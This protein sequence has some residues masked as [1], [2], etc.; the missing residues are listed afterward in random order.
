MAVTQE[1]LV[2]L[3]AVGQRV[4]QRDMDDSAKSVE[5]VGKASESTAKAT[6]KSFAKWV[7]ASGAVAAGSKVLK[8]SIGNAVDLG[9]QINK[10]A[11][12]F[13]GPGAKAVVDWSKSTATAIGV[14]RQQALEA[15]GTFGNMLVPMGFARTQAAGMS[16]KLVTLAGDMASFNNANPEDTLEALRSGLAGETEPLRKYGVFLNDAR[17]KAEAMGLGLVHASRDQQKIKAS[18]LA[19]ELAQRKYNAA[20]NK[21]GAHSQQAKQA[22]L[23]NE[24]AQVAL[25]KATKGSIPQLT[26]AQKAQATYSLILKDTKDAQ[27]DFG[28]TSDSLANKQRILKAQYAN[29]T[30]TLGQQLVPVLQLLAN[31]LDVVAAA[32][33]VLTTAWVA[34]RV[35]ALYAAASQTALNASIFLIPTAIIAVVAALVIAYKKVGWFHDA[36]NATF[37]WIKS[38]WP[39]LAAILAGPFG[40]AA[41][42][43]IRNFDKIKNA[44][45]ATVSWIAKRFRDLVDFFKRLPGGVLGKVGGL[46]GKIT[47]FQHGGVSRGGTALVGEAGPE[48]VTLPGGTRVT[49]LP[50]LGGAGLGGPMVANLYLDR[51]LVA[52]AVAQ[53]DA[54]VRARR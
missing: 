12:V 50:A 41:L 35:A 19:A 10:T 1:V 31:N 17:V 29:I 45:N 52:T 44:A 6:T 47:P 3:R 2:R 24:R 7:A 51:R 37:N 34:Y 30:A 15:A 20:V 4:F 46:L 26:A 22:L 43:I 5:G 39:L 53:R 13:R 42:A 27:G 16:S 48:L 36:V 23:A 49:P 21:Y 11:V 40:I 28:R 8:D 38:H 9:E 18:Q 14:S 33:A 25:G 54:D 32:V